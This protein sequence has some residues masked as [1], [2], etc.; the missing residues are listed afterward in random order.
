M[1]LRRILDLFRFRWLRKMLIGKARFR[2]DTEYAGGKWDYLGAPQQLNYDV[3]LH[4]IRHFGRQPSILEVGCGEGILQQRIPAGTYSKFL[5][6]DISKI[7]IDRAARLNNKT[8]E[9]RRADM[10]RF[11]PPEKY[12]I[13]VLNEVLHYSADPI[14]LLKRYSGFLYPG[15]LMITSLRETAHSLTIIAGIEKE[16]IILDKKYSGDEKRAWHC[17]VFQPKQGQLI[18]K[19]TNLVD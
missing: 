14:G 12:Q 13:I 9:Y 6:I 7:A 1:T 4:F 18:L 2:W 15:G 10:E 8:T 11:T 5:G 17:H 3:I 19:S 16:F